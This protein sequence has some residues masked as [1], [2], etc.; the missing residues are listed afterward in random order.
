M[1][2][3]DALEK[4]R[5]HY[6]LPESWPGAHRAHWYRRLHGV[7]PGR[8]LVATQLA[9]LANPEVPIGL[10]AVV[11]QVHALKDGSTKAP[12]IQPCALCDELPG[13]RELLI[14]VRRGERIER[15]SVWAACDCA[16]G[17]LKDALS[18]AHAMERAKQN[19]AVVGVYPA[20]RAA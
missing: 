17:A 1:S 12:P 9:I 18:M 19:S 13:M 14:D 7:P 15:Q 2:I 8:I 3:G 5:A 20:R 10:G 4:V 6:A 16:A 11:H